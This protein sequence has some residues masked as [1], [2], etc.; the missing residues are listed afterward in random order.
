M[1]LTGPMMN[2]YIMM[3]NLKELDSD[4]YTVL[5]NIIT[6]PEIEKL[7]QIYTYSA[8]VNKIGNKKR[9]IVRSWN[10][11]ILD[12]KIYDLMSA[13]NSNTSLKLDIIS[14]GVGYFDTAFYNNVWHQDHEPVTYY[15]DAFNAINLWIPLVKPDEHK[16]GLD[17]I[18]FSKLSPADITYFKGF[19]ARRIVSENNKTYALD[20]NNRGHRTDFSFDINELSVSPAISVGDVLVMRGDTI[21]KTQDTDTHRIALSIRCFKR[22]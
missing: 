1:Q 19:G 9:V 21:H 20:D 17:I 18:P 2:K 10:T 3:N 13:I 8:I 15:K 11:G 16:S 7:Y 6:E 22:V 5:K 12:T 4:G 14:S